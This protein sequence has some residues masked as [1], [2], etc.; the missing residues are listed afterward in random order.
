MQLIIY[1]L[2]SFCWCFPQDVTFKEKQKRYPRVRQA[3][4]NYYPKVKKNLEQ[5]SVP[6]ESLRLYLRAF[7]K[8]REIE[9]WGQDP[10]TRKFRLLRSFEVCRLS[11]AVGPKRRQGDGQIPEGFYHLDRF[12]PA[13][14]F[15]LSLGINYPNRSDK[16]LG[17]KG[18]LGGDIFIHGDCVTI[19]CL[20]ITNPQIEELYVYCVEAKNSGQKSIPVTIFPSRLTDREFERLKHDYPTQHEFIGLWSSLKKGYDYFNSTKKLPTIEFLETGDYLV[21]P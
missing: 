17:T 12:N 9:L 21:K 20:P 2:I 19:G 3:Y 1:L 14:S 10:V 5:K 6:I 18:R 8:E 7:K 4:S 16:I 15:H 13:S 11:G